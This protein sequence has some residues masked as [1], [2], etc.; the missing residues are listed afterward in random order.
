VAG[1]EFRSDTDSL[2]FG[3]LVTCCTVSESRRALK[4]CDDLA[5]RCHNSDMDYRY[6]KSQPIA[7]PLTDE[8]YTSEKQPLVDSELAAQPP[9]HRPKKSKFKKALIIIL[10]LF[11]ITAFIR[12]V[13]HKIHRHH[14]G[15]GPHDDP[16]H[17]KHPVVRHSARHPTIFYNGGFRICTCLIPTQM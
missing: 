13:S 12:W 1:C 6:I 15:H 2:K 8:P 16:P 7:L 4:G 10:H 3:I 9:T 11:L 14:H 17:R 5:S